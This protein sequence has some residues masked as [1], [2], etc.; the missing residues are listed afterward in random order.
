MG[1]N[2]FVAGFLS[3]KDKMQLDEC[4]LELD[5]YNIS[6]QVRNLNGTIMHSAFDFADV[7]II[8]FSYEL[9]KAL[10]YAGL[11]DFLKYIILKLWHTVRK[12][13]PSNIPFTI[14]IEGIPTINGPENLKFKISGSLSQDEKKIALEKSFELASQVEKHQAELLNKSI[15]NDAFNARIFAYDQQGSAYT[16]ID[17]AKE[18]QKKTGKRKEPTVNSSDTEQT[19]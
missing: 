14:D 4:R 2:I 11:Y 8:A 19:T 15:Y 17:I 10:Y 16:E 6:L 9:V 13:P 5:K 12:G 1:D 18:A 3:D 7:E